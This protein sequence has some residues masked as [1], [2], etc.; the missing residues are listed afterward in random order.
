M[1]DAQSASGSNPSFKFHL[2]TIEHGR[3]LEDGGGI[4]LEGPQAA[5]LVMTNCGMIQYFETIGIGGFFF[6][7]SPA[8]TLDKAGGTNWNHL[9]ASR[10]GYCDGNSMG[11]DASFSLP[12]MLGNIT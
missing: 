4:Y 3:A 11:V 6:V 5:T 12:C 10:A 8:F 7:G 2:S 1:S 9:N